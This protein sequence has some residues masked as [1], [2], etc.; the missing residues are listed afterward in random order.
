MS[1]DKVV[2]NIDDVEWRRQN[3]G[4]E[5]DAKIKDLSDSTI[6]EQ[7][8]LRLYELAPGKSAWPFHA[9][10]AN[11]EVIFI[12]EGEGTLRFEEDEYDVSEGD[13]LSF[14]ADPDSPHKLTN[15]SDRVLRYLCAST[16]RQPDAIRYPDSEKIG[17]FAGEPPGGESD[18]R[19]F[20]G[21]YDTNCEKDY[22]EDEV[23]ED[24]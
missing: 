20:Q 14:P 23:P 13:C 2:L 1:E 24:E 6:L 4:G 7:L 5:Y 10:M 8:G 16:M 19:S 15:T 18:D 21:V 22:W 3:P 11:E 17:I 9:H 12:Q